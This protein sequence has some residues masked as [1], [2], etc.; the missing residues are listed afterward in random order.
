M[1]QY[2][3]STRGSGIGNVQGG[4]SHCSC[5]INRQYP[6]LE[7]GKHIAVNRASQHRALRRIATQQPERPNFRFRYRDRRKEKLGR[8]DPIRPMRRPYGL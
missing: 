1:N 8:V 6:A 3:R 2:D 5:S 4:A 7:C